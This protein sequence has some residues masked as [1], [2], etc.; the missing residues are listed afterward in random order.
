MAVICTGERRV[1]TASI[2]GEVD[3]HRARE[4]ME[5]LGRHIDAALPRE[6]ILDLEGV[7]F[8][9]SSGIAVLL[10][11]HRRLEE[12]GGRVR[13]IHVPEQAGK[14]LRTAGVQRLIPLE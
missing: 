13:V 7:T 4:I 6:L 10:R 9:D 14:V 8:M 5:E 1:M 2:T 12:L 3:H 11:A